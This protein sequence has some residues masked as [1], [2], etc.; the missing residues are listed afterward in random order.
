M[1]P[2]HCANGAIW[3]MRNRSRKASCWL[4]RAAA[5]WDYA[6]SLCMP[7]IDDGRTPH[8]S[9]MDA[10]IAAAVV[11]DYRAS[12]FSARG[13]PQITVGPDC[14]GQTSVAFEIRGVS[15]GFGVPTA[16]LLRAARLFSR[17]GRHH[18]AILNIVQDGLANL[19]RML[20]DGFAPRSNHEGT[21]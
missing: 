15:L 12:L 14:N 7:G 13:F 8:Y 11:Y 19:E 20:P 6:T 2:P 21:A 5:L 1:K 9:Y 17:S 4:S 18:P 10:A 3:A 16:T